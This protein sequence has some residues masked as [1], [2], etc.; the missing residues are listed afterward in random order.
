MKKPLLK[1]EEKMSGDIW[2]HVTPKKGPLASIN[3]GKRGNHLK[4]SIVHSSLQHAI[5]ESRRPSLEDSAVK[6]WEYMRGTAD[7]A[8]LDQLG[9]DGWELVSSVWTPEV[10]EII[11]FFKREIASPHFS[12][13][14]R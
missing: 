13:G 1:L 9:A 8:Q 7:D 4:P 6:R 5:A 11:H 3:L 2:L 12:T 14:P 10:S